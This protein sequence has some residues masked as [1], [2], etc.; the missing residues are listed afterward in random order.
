MG[1]IRPSAAQV[2][3]RAEELLSSAYRSTPEAF[4]TLAKLRGDDGFDRIELAIAHRWTA[5]P[6]WGLS[7]WDLGS[8]PW[9]VIFHRATR[10]AYELAHNIEG[11]VTT[12]RYP[13]RAL[14]DIATDY[15]A[16]VHW[17]DA[18]ESWVDAVENVDLAPA[19][20]RGPFSS[21]RFEARRAG[22]F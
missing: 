18:G 20:L 21:E 22:P 7:G 14:R 12:Y 2:P 8:W 17:K 16:F 11:D 6:S 10:H 9:V 13:A 5:I 1:T 19:H 15:L 4:W 3:A